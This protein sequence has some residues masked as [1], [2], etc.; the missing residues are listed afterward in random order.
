VHAES[1]ILLPPVHLNGTFSLGIAV[2]VPARQ[3][4]CYRKLLREPNAGGRYRRLT[5]LNRSVHTLSADFCSCKIGTSNI[6]VGRDPAPVIWH[7]DSY[8]HD[9]VTSQIHLLQFE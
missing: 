3:A 4:T 1:E 6:H 9:A 2:T 7:R 5:N 8:P